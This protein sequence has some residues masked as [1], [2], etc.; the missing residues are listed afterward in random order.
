MCKRKKN[1][2]LFNAPFEFYIRICHIAECIMLF[3]YK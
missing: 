2:R 1:S 3:P